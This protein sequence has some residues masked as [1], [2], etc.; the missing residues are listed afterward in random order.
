LTCTGLI[1]NFSHLDSDYFH[2]DRNIQTL[3][4]STFHIIPSD[5]GGNR[6]AGSILLILFSYVLLYFN[7]SKKK[8][9]LNLMFHDIPQYASD[10]CIASLLR[11][12]ILGA[13]MIRR[14]EGCLECCEKQ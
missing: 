13:K 9:N 1:Y 3:C 6:V 4:V 11:S 7:P 10:F 8:W 12:R 5:E 2:L 14:K